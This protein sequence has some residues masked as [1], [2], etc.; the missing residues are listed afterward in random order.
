MDTT[1]DSFRLSI[2]RVCLSHK[3]M[4]LASPGPLAY[5]RIVLV[6]VIRVLPPSRRLRP[7]S[8]ISGLAAKDRGPRLGPSS[9]LITHLKWKPY[10]GVHAIIY[11]L[12]T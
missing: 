1:I 4:R 3:M 7:W 8:E 2:N 5:A 11:T 10:T 9:P 12:R 6:E